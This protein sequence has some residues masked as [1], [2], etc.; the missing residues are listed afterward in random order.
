MRHHYSSVSVGFVS[1]ELEA[2]FREDLEERG[3]W[4]VLLLDVRPP[5]VELLA[6]I[7]VASGIWNCLL[8]EV[9]SLNDEPLNVSATGVEASKMDGVRS[10]VGR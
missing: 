8:L 4:N 5:R 6:V 7:V 9:G 10:G 3:G 1:P 2:R